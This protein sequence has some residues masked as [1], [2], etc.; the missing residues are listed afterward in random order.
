MHAPSHAQRDRV[1]RIHIAVKAV[2]ARARKSVLCLI[3]STARE[4]RA[5]SATLVSMYCVKRRCWHSV[6]A[7]PSC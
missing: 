1:P 4:T 2:T 7:D 5:D 6:D 3:P